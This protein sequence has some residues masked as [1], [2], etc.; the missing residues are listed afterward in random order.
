MRFVSCGCLAWSPYE[1][2]S[3]VA[4]LLEWPS[5]S[6]SHRGAGYERS[7]RCYP[8]EGHRDWG[9]KQTTSGKAWRWYLARWAASWKSSLLFSWMREVISLR[10]NEFL[11]YL[12]VQEHNSDLLFLDWYYTKQE[13]VHS[14]IDSIVWNELNSTAILTGIVFLELHSYT[15]ILPLPGYRWLKYFQG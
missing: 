6:P 4:A 12:T 5:V 11:N 9:R 7:P 14:L 15:K 10:R 8:I 13:S 3:W 1:L 2:D